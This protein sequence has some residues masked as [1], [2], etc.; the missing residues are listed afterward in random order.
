MTD[1]K[2]VNVQITDDVRSIVIRRSEKANALNPEV[3]DGLRQ[4][5]TSEPGPR[6]RVAVLSSQG[7]VFCAGMDFD[8]LKSRGVAPIPSPI[9]A[10]LDA[11]EHYPLPVVTV[12]QGDAI[13]GGMQLALHCDFV[14][15]ADTARFGMSLV[16]IGLAPVWKVAK[17]VVDVMGPALA[18]EVLL[19]GD[20][21]PAARMAALGVI[22]AAVPAEELATESARLVARLKANAPLSLRAAKPLLVRLIAG[23][24]DPV[25]DDLDALVNAA[26]NSNDA[27]EG[28]TARLARREANFQGS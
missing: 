15:A 21:M 20:P 2:L 5:F 13:A 8:Y 26:R 22:Y 12:V 27:R 23:Q 4:A 3:L 28:M 1:T 7:H 14:V 16:Q 19:G 24:A 10:V 25:H 17:K 11:I 6:E 18:R 9:E